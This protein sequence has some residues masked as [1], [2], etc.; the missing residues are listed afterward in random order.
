MFTAILYGTFA[1]V[2]WFGV[3]ALVGLI[4]IF[5]GNVCK[6]LAKERKAVLQGGGGTDPFIAPP[7]GAMTSAIAA[8]Y[9]LSNGVSMSERV[10]YMAAV[11]AVI[12]GVSTYLGFYGGF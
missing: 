11:N 6:V 12:F 8:A 7:G 5:L 3:G 2:I 9:L 10:Y 1:E 4:G